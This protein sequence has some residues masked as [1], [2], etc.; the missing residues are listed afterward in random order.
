MHVH[1]YVRRYCVPDIYILMLRQHGFLGGNDSF[2]VVWLAG[3]TGHLGWLLTRTVCPK[4]SWSRRNVS[5]DTERLV[6]T[7]NAVAQQIVDI[8]KIVAKLVLHLVVLCFEVKKWQHQ[9][10]IDRISLHRKCVNKTIWLKCWSYEKKL[11]LD[12]LATWEGNC[13]SFQMDLTS[14]I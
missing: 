14:W 13:F 4:I 7:F 12:H 11:K 9:K 3:W 1:T 5:V 10:K 2:C 8:R 6:Q